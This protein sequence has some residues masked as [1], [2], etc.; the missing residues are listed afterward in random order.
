MTNKNTRQILYEKSADIDR[1]PLGRSI[2]K[3]CRANASCVN[4]YV[5]LS[6]NLPFFHGHNSMTGNAQSPHP[7]P[8]VHTPRTYCTAASP[9]L[10]AVRGVA[11]FVLD[12]DAVNGNGGAIL[13]PD[14]H[15]VGIHIEVAGKQFVHKEP[16][17][18]IKVMSVR[19]SKSLP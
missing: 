12:G 16:S 8:S 15:P 17:F 10:P 1:M 6:I 2:L 4:C 7:A 3:N 5:T 13:E 14:F 19:L 18:Y 9:A 11:V